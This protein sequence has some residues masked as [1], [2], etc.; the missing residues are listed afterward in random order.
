MAPSYANLFMGRLEDQFLGKRDLKPLCWLRFIDDI[1]AIWPHGETELD[2]FLTCLNSTSIVKFT[3]ATSTSHVTFLDVDV[4]LEEGVLRTNV[5]FKPTNNLQYLHHDSCHPTYTKRALPHS[6]AVRGRRICSNE[7]DLGEYC[8]RITNA[9]VARGYPREKVQQQIYRP[10]NQLRDPQSNII[11]LIT[12]WHPGLHVLNGILK[13]GLNILASS[14]KTEHLTQNLPRVTFRRPRNIG[15]LVVRR[16]CQIDL[17]EVTLPSGS[18]PC[19]KPRC[20]TCP[21]HP[22]STSFTAQ[23]TGRTYPIHKHNTC[24]SHNVVYQLKCTQCPAEYVGLTSNPLRIRM[25]GHR[26]NVNM[27]DME[28]PVAEHAASHQLS[29]NSCFT[30]R[31]IRS[32]PA[33]CT[34]GELRRYEISCQ[35]ITKSRLPPNLNIR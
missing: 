35:W 7:K 10:S 16:Y 4:Y 2:S 23:A 29:F 18:Y 32:F 14:A 31:I 15:D 25:T 34:P 30:T 5:H 20:K 13:S 19:K 27:L 11:P 8:D 1:F 26:Q 3:W 12:E 6:L 22:P 33:N 21:M 9:F 28:K 17:P 24:D